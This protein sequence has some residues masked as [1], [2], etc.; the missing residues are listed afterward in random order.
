[1]KSSGCKLT[2]STRV[3][4]GMSPLGAQH[5]QQRRRLNCSAGGIGMSKFKL[6]S[7][8]NVQLKTDILS[9]V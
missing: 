3:H 6:F 9:A 1:M 5:S 2:F 7:R 8:S 4:Q